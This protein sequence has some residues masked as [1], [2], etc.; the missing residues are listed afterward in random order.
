MLAFRKLSMF[1]MIYKPIQQNST[2]RAEEIVP[3]LRLGEEPLP[4]FTS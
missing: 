1:P 3:G 2:N 4:V